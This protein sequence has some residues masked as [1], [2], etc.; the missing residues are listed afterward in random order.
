MWFPAT[1][2]EQGVLD[3][4]FVGPSVKWME[5]RS[6]LLALAKQQMPDEFWLSADERNE[7]GMVSGITIRALC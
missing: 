5:V 6:A 4:L 3:Q 1:K 2:P 7:P